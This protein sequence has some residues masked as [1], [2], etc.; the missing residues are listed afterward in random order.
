MD[1]K[2][3][4][5]R[6]GVDCCHQVERQPSRWSDLHSSSASPP[7]CTC[8]PPPCCTWPSPPCCTWPSPPPPPCPTPSP[9]PCSLAGEVLRLVSAPEQIHV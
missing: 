4:P 8:H 3:S 2:L 7:C 1:I 9:L 6:A 5:Q